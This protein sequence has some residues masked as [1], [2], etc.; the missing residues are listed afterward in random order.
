MIACVPGH[1]ALDEKLRGCNIGTYLY[2]KNIIGSQGLQ[3]LTEIEF[4][5]RQ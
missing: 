2:M 4:V 5:W 1:A 3:D